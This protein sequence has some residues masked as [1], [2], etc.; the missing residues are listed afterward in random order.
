MPSFPT[1]NY[2]QSPPLHKAWGFA[3]LHPGFTLF[4]RFAGYNQA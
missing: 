2:L 4:T 1:S 3:A